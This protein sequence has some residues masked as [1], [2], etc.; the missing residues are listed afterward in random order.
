[1]EN[2]DPPLFI[3]VREFP[4][5]E[6]KDCRRARQERN[7][8]SNSRIHPY[9]RFIAFE[10]W[11]RFIVW[12]PTLRLSSVKPYAALSYAVCEVVTS[13]S[14]RIFTPCTSSDVKSDNNQP[15]HEEK[16]ASS[17]KWIWIYPLSPHLM[18]WCQDCDRSTWWIGI[19]YF[20]FVFCVCVITPC[21]V[22]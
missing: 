10:I 1:M 20:W 4:A 19:I 18:G 2:G 9:W 21:E 6:Y 11:I 17:H 15:C 8:H 13:V 5:Q 12:R 14:K 3:F 16:Q 7:I 22:T